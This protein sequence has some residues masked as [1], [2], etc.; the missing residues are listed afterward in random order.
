MV[1][2]LERKSWEMVCRGIA[3]RLI[4]DM[5]ELVYTRNLK[6]RASLWHVGSSP[7]IPTLFNKTAQRADW[8]RLMGHQERLDETKTKMM[9]F[10][11]HQPWQ[12]M[13]LTS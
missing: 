5:V 7:T 12:P 8:T 10:F 13:S 6:F 3:T 9:T 1:M 2:R 4:G 11:L